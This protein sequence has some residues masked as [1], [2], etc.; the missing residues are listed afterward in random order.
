MTIL[1]NIAKKNQMCKNVTL[2]KYDKKYDKHR[3]NQMYK[4]VI[5]PRVTQLLT[6]KPIN[7]VTV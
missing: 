1:K 6:I 5:V 3:E 2:S 4:N 7:Y